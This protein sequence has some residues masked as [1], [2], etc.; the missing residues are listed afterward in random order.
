MAKKLADPLGS[1]AAR[2]VERADH[3]ILAAPE[4]LQ[5]LEPQ[6][7]TS[8]VEFGHAA[9]DVVDALLQRTRQMDAA[10]AIERAG[11]LVAD[12]RDPHDLARRRHSVERGTVG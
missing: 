4:L 8:V 5:R 2:A 11:A 6:I 9:R 3:E 10:V 12:Q 7:E 1:E